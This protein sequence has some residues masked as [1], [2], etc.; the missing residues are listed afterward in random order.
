MIDDLYDHSKVHSPVI[1]QAEELRANL[2]ASF[3]SFW[4]AMVKSNV[5]HGFWLVRLIFC[6]KFENTIIWPVLNSFIWN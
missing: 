5:T 1:E 4:K 3:P 6:L 2:E